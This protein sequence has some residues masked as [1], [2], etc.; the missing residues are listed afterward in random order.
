LVRSITGL[1][2]G[3][4][5]PLFL[6]FIQNAEGKR[7][8]LKR[9]S[10]LNVFVPLMIS[11]AFIFLLTIITTSLFIF[12]VLIIVAATGFVLLFSNLV[13]TLRCLKAPGLSALTK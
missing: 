11:S 13:I 3:V 6:I 10:F 8:L 2:T 7:H 9:I 1:L 4:T 5:L 12:H